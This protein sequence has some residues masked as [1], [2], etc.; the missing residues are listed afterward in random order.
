MIKKTGHFFAAIFTLSLFGLTGYVFAQDASPPMAVG[1]MPP[2]AMSPAAAPMGAGNAQA[3]PAIN[4]APSSP[5][6]QVDG[7]SVPNEILILSQVEK[8]LKEK[9]AKDFF[10]PP[11]I[12][13]LLFTNVQQARLQEA[14]Q[15]FNS[16]AESG[17]LSTEELPDDVAEKELAALQQEEEIK[18]IGP[19]TISLGGI[20]FVSP[21]EWTI[22]LNK[23]RVTPDRLPKSV[24]DLRVYKDFVELK[25]LDEHSKEIFP[26]RLR[27]NQKFSLD[28]RIFLPGVETSFSDEKEKGKS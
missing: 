7:Q 10:V 20:V 3:N 5:S 23:Q 22:W 2:T 11:Q 13:S 21:D 6:T 1:Q 18:P 12:G 9:F 4:Q 14:R 25:W 28:G 19:R 17:L 16:R 8:D 15:G 26:I 27:P 24:L